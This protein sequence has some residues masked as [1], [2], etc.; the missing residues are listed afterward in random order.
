[1]NG[2]LLVPFGVS[3]EEILYEILRKF[4]CLS[5]RGCGTD[6]FPRSGDWSV[7]SRGICSQEAEREEHCCSYFLVFVQTCTLRHRIT[8][9]TYTQSSSFHIS[10]T[11]LER[12]TQT[13]MSKGVSL[14]LI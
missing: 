13:N 8:G 1:M 6:K 12:V 3:C 2:A 10:Q 5:I 14:R 9:M 11:S 4:T 7:R